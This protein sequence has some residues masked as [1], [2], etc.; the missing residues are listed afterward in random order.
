MV[1]TVVYPFNQGQ[2]PHCHNWKIHINIKQALTP[3][4]LF[5]IM[6]STSYVIQGLTLLTES[7]V[8]PNIISRY[9]PVNFD[10]ISWA[11][12]LFEHLRSFVSASDLTVN[13]IGNRN[14][15]IDSEFS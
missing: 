10:S 5:T 12:L 14:A 13:Y 15:R 4:H 1:N 8:L 3:I 2:N 6:E 11:T 9:L 7:L